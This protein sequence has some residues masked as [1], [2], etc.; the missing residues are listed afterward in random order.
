[1]KLTYLYICLSI[2][3]G[4]QAQDVQKIKQAFS[5][6]NAQV[7]TQDLA[8]EVEYCINDDVQYL[9]KNETLNVLNK[10]IHQVQP[11]NVTGELAGEGQ[12]KYF[13]GYIDTAKGKYKLVLYFRQN[14]AKVYRID[15]IRISQ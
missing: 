14:N 15:E 5:S 3:T 4:L 12:V 7:I 9:S 6:R 10:W 1:M 13:K 8:D 11:T 2:A